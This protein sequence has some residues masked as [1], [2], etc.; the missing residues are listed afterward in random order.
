MEIFRK[1]RYQ[2]WWFDSVVGHHHCR[3]SGLFGFCVDLDRWTNN[4]QFFLE[5]VISPSNLGL[6]R[7][8]KMNDEQYHFRGLAEEWEPT[9][10]KWNFLVQRM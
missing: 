1:R 3:A 6:P 8:F 2:A 4:L 5:R 9:I 7:V 10:A